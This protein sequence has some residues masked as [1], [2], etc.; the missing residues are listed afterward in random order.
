MS[1]KKQV[2]KEG[3][4]VFYIVGNTVLSGNVADI[5]LT[6]TGYKFAIDSY[7]ACEGNFKIDSA[8]IGINVFQNREDAEKLAK[9]PDYTG[10]FQAFC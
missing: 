5:E 3:T 7:G 2:L 1:D 10:G 4:E 8:M 6:K 9:D